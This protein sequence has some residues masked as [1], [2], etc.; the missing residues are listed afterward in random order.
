LA[1]LLAAIPEDWQLFFEFLAHTGMRISEATGLRWEFVELGER[2]RIKVRDQFYRGERK[3]LKSGAGRRD[4]PL[5]AGMT[6]TTRPP[7]R[8]L[9]RPRV[10]RVP[11]DGRNPRQP[12]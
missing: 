1:L 2:S 10:A 5:S 3:A 12:E 4:I 7:P 8:R 9:Q 6:A 11:V